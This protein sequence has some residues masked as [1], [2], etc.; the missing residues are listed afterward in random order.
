MIEEHVR[1]AEKRPCSKRVRVVPLFFALSWALLGCGDQDGD[2]NGAPAT[3]SAPLATTTTTPPSSSTVASTTTIALT[4]DERAFVVWP[5]PDSAVRYTDPVK[6]ARSF[7]VEFVGFENPVMGTLREG[8]GR[9]G[10]IAVRPSATGPETTVL[11]RRFGPEGSWWVIG[12]VAADI[13]VTMPVPQSAVDDPLQMAGR[14]RAFEGTVEVDVIVDGSTARVGSGFV[15]G[16]SG[17]D[18]G[19]FTGS[20]RFA[21]PRGG[22]GSVIF[23]TRSM[24]NGQIWEAATVRVG[25]I[26]GD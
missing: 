2:G 20:M 11:V 6:V 12:S 8:D 3:S 21:S 22:W 25:F 4:V 17:P 1:D 7:A 9:S 26:G 14:S 18:L 13:E 23:F 16:G 15:T 5:F 19:P 24:E 10:E